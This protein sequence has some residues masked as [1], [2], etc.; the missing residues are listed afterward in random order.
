MV[1]FDTPRRPVVSLQSWPDCQITDYLPARIRK[2][3]QHCHLQRLIRSPPTPIAKF[4]ATAPLLKGVTVLLSYRPA[5][6][7]V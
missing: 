2:Q 7:V 1:W 3:W 5:P 4:V 6:D